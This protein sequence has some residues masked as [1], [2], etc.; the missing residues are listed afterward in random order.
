MFNNFFLA[1]IGSGRPISQVVIDSFLGLIAR[2]SLLFPIRTKFVSFFGL[3]RGQSVG[4]TL[5]GAILS[6]TQS[7]QHHMWRRPPKT[8]SETAQ[9]KRE[10]A[11][12][13]NPLHRLLTAVFLIF[14]VQ[15]VGSG[16]AS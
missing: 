13:G 14:S 15:C 9:I 7:K 11:V 3:Y 6:D 1:T 10:Q 5:P 2:P 4:P 12:W 16:F 8:D